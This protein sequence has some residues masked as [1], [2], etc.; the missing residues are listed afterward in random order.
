MITLRK[1]RVSF[2]TEG[3]PFGAGLLVSACILVL[4][5]S[6]GCRKQSAS[7]IL[8]P[9]I[10]HDKQGIACLDCH[11]S[12]ETGDMAGMPQHENCTQCHEINP[13]MDDSKCQQCH[14]NK[15]NSFKS[16]VPILYKQ[17]VFSHQNHASEEVLCEKCHTQ[18]VK[19]FEI[20]GTPYPDM[21]D[22]IHCHQAQKAPLN[23]KACH[24]GWDKEN[25]PLWHK[26][27]FKK[28]HGPLSR[29]KETR[30]NTCHAKESCVQC[31]SIE[32]PEGHNTFFKQKGHGLKTSWERKRCMAC[33]SSDFCRR[34]H[35]STLPSSHRGSFSRTHCY[36]CHLPKKETGCIVCHSQPG[37][38]AIT[39]VSRDLAAQ[40]ELVALMKANNCMSCHYVSGSGATTPKHP[41]KYPCTYCHLFD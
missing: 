16:P 15:D 38:T 39:N 1:H 24:P 26:G 9:H 18:I 21:D 12:A 23:C 17:V 28:L 5:M 19:S 20:S 34:C 4:I 3:F 41:P 14:L 11:P 25:P 40:P 13:Q 10:V 37:H 35:E 32:E 27:A 8:F 7:G 36:S 2:R 33:H 29:K 22:C 31:H 6:A 30:C